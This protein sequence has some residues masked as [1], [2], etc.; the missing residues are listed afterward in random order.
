MRDDMAKVIVERPRRKASDRLRGRLG[1]DWESQPI[2]QG[3]KYRWADTKSLNENLAPLRRYLARQV[4][5]PWAKVYSE[6]SANLKAT[7]AVQQ[8]VRD[9]LKDYVAM[10][11]SF[12]KAGE[13]MSVSRWW[14]S[15]DFYVDPRDGIL[16]RAKNDTDK[17]RKRA[18]EPRRQRLA[19]AQSEV[20]KIKLASGSDLRR[21]NGIWF[22]M[23]YSVSPDGTEVISQ[24]RQLSTK[25]LRQRNLVN[26]AV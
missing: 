26:Q 13:P 23:N 4:G 6:I 15:Y 5:R 8:H 18:K 12:N 3:M 14:R 17:A 1:S 25:E 10:K 2:N 9:H 21:L 24:K 19:L 22:V 11:V 20:N 16:K 7:N